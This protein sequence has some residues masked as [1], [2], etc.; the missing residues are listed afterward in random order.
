MMPNGAT[1]YYFS[2]SGTFTW[3][4]AVQEAHKLRQHC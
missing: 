3:Q 1:Y 2:D 4:A